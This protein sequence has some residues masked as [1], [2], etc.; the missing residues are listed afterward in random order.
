MRSARSQSVAD[1]PIGACGGLRHHWG[2]GERIVPIFIDRGARH[3]LGRVMCL[4]GAPWGN[5]RG[6]DRQGFEIPT[7]L[8]RGKYDLRV[9]FLRH[10]AIEKAADSK[11]S[12]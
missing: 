10:G 5:Y 12:Q 3:D 9:G 6:D 11:E 1:L 7:S 8:R 4:Q 2:N